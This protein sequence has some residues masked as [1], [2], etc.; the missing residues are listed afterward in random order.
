MVQHAINDPNFF[1]KL[2]EFG[3][4]K[5]RGKVLSSKTRSSGG[6]SGCRKRREF[7]NFLRE[8]LNVVKAL[9]GAGAQRLKQ[10]L[11]AERLMFQGINRDTGQYETKII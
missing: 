5:E 8:F 9:D 3:Q 10:Y 4:L 6:C 2:P 11:G 1:R 7:R